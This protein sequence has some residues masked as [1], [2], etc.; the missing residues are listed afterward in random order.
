MKIYWTVP[1]AEDLQSIYD[2]IAHDSAFYAASFIEKILVTTEKLE[3]NPE[4]GRKVPEIDDPNI[5]ELIFQNY[6]IM[7]RLNAYAIQVI[8]VLRGSRDIGKW[9]L[10][11]W[12]IV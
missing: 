5:R 1:A 10:K 11:P 12:E 8:A 2:Y 9:P 4:I 3:A 7:Y 6:R